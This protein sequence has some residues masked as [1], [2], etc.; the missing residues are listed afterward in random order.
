MNEV[1]KYHN[2]LNTVVMRNWTPLEMNIFFSIISKMRDKGTQKVTFSVDELRELTEKKENRQPKRWN[3]AMID[4]SR[5]ISQLNYYYEDNDH[6]IL[7]MLF[8]MFDVNKREQTLTIKV[9]EHFEYILNRLNVS[10]TTYELREFT[11]LKSS[12]SKTMYR[13]LK[14]WRTIG[15]K[16]FSVEEFRM[17]L[18]VPKSYSKGTIDKQILKPIKEELST[19]FN[20]LKIKKI[21]ENTRGNPITHYEFTWQ[22]EHTEPWLENKYDEQPQDYAPKY[23]N[24]FTEWLINYGVLSAH[25]HELIEQF[26]LEVYPLYQQLADRATLETVEKHI[27]YVAKQRYKHPV[28]YFKK[29]AKDYLGRF[30]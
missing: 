16:R 13:L 30:V 3:E 22:P 1:V 8:S 23:E 11:N 26:K 21:Q 4:V 6:Y 24:K 17:L 20:N 10:F 5:K 25:D 2:D 19:Y 12:Y 29:A 7:M 28:G 9:S 15:K 18:D 27:S 14:Q